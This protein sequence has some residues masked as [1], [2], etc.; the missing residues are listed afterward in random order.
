MEY[1]IDIVKTPV[2]DL[3]SLPYQKFPLFTYDK[4]SEDIWRNNNIKIE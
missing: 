1:G 4:Y 2:D 3:I